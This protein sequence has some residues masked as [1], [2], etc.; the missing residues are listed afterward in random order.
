MGQPHRE[1]PLERVLAVAETLAIAAE[2]MANVALKMR[3]NAMKEAIFAWTTRQDTCV[4]LV[5][6]LCRSCAE[7]LPEQILE[8]KT[9]VKSALRID[10]ERSQKQVAKNAKPTGDKSEPPK[11]RNPKK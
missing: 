4:S 3:E 8:A 2:Q 10:W 5:A 11:K 6:R 7:Y 1:I 9:G